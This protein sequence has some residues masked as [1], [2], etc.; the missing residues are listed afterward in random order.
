MG[1]DRIW[2]GLTTSPRE[3]RGVVVGVRVRIRWTETVDYE[4]E[5]EVPPGVQV[6]DFVYEH[7]W[8]G[9]ADFTQVARVSEREVDGWRVVSDPELG[10]Q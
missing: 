8:L 6:N 5:F 9:Q 7:R 1:V 10:E 2:A 4:Q 3:M